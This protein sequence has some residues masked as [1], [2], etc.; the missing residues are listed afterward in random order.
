MLAD[1]N[2]TYEQL[3]L[4]E[5][6]NRSGAGYDLQDVVIVVD[7]NPSSLI[8]ADPNSNFPD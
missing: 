3:Y 7:N 8:S 4:V 6:G 1:L 2:D 5:L